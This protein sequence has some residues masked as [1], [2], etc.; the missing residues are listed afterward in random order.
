MD[1]RRAARIGIA[2]ATV[3][4]VA[5]AAGFWLAWGPGQRP[6][7]GLVHD[8]TLNNA[9]NGVWLAVLAAVVL[10]LQPGNRIG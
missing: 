8:N 6:L 2:L 10:R 9:A 4:A 3:G 1:H 7:S 5:A